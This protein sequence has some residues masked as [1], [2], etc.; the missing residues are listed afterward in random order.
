MNVIIGI[1]IITLIGYLFLEKTLT[2]LYMDGFT[3]KKEFIKWLFIPYY[4]I[5]VGIK[6]A[7]D[8]YKNMED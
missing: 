5:I 6:S 3:S 2:I 4:S 7:I 1:L 8:V